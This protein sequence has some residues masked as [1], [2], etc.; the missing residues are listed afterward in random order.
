MAI[1]YGGGGAIGSIIFGTWKEIKGFVSL[2]EFND[3][4][5]RMK[6]YSEM[7]IVDD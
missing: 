4:K 5:I 7:K 1:W 2:T 6:K 3:M